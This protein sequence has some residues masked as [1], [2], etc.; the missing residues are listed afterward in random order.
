MNIDQYEDKA[1][2]REPLNREPNNL[3]SY[4][5]SSYVILDLMEKT[6]RD[7]GYY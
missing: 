3:C 6:L 5:S 1:T 2:N 7:L 4:K